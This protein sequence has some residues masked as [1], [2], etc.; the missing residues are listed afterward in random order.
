LAEF[1]AALQAAATT[2]AT[3]ATQPFEIVL[4]AGPKDHGPGEHDYPLWQKRWSKLLPLAENVR[5]GTAWEWPSP[6]QRKT[7]RVIVFYSNLPGWNS[8]RAAELEAFLQRGGGAVFLHYAVDGHNE[9]D[10]LAKL[11]GLAWKGGHS[12]F[13]HGPLDL[14]LEPGPLT[15]GLPRA[16][17]VDE[18]YW[19]LLGDLKD[20]KLVASGVEDGQPQPL[21]WTREHGPGRVFVSIPGH[22][23]WTFDDPIFRLLLLRGICWAGGQPVDRLSEL[24][25]IGARVSE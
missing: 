20:V 22:Y 6:E 21:M 23:S 5:V 25:L 24:A 13:R 4:C 14:K 10:Q 1:Q 16:E 19:K 15:T 9:V 11:I 2:G 17:F 7:A 8:T 12:K 18:S 3:N